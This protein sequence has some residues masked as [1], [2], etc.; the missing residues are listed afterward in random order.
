M[1]ANAGLSQM[2]D[3]L[4]DGTSYGAALVSARYHA[5]SVIENVASPSSLCALNY[6][7]MYLL[8]N[9]PFATQHLKPLKWQT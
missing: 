1:R 3:S 4:W 5:A 6:Y 8:K 9:L 7:L 2:G